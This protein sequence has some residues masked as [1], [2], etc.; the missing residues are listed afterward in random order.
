[1]KITIRK[2]VLLLLTIT[3][4]LG[5]SY[6]LK[7]AYIGSSYAAKIA[8][9]CHFLSG[10]ELADI[11]ENDLYAVPFVD[12]DIDEA[13]NTVSSSIYG[14]AKTTAVYRDGFGCSLLNEISADSKKSF[15]T[16]ISFSYS[17]RCF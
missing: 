11:K 16:C 14:L 2:V 13:G 12:L 10:R 9:S 5:I 8:C 6:G 4:F 17:F 7:Y 15:S 1:M 3:L